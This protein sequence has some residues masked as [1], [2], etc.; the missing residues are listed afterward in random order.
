MKT[1][2]KGQHYVT[3]AYLRKFATG[4]GRRAMLYVYERDRDEPYRQKPERAARVTNYYSIRKEDGSWDD[5]I[6]DLLGQVESTAVP[7]IERLAIAD[8]EPSWNDRINISTFIGFQEFRVPWTRQQMENLYKGL[9]SHMMRFTAAVPG[10]MEADLERM[11]AKGIDVKDVTA[12]QLREMIKGGRYEI[13]VNPAASLMPMLE[14]VP[15]VSQIYAQMMWTV[16]CS[17]E[18]SLFVTSDNPVV[19]FDPTYREGFYGIGIM[20]RYIEI[21]FPLTRTA[22]LVMTHDHERLQDILEL[23]DAGETVKA[24]A[25]RNSLPRTKFVRVGEETAFFIN[26]LTIMHAKTNVYSPTRLDYAPQILKGEPGGIR[27]HVG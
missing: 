27:I 25:V 22:C 4:S 17:R 12:D 11:K 2:P 20:N 5:S 16:L 19:K 23:E 9:I 1:R 14:Q 24:G 6:E 18:G 3:A 21:R 26:S 15:E 7:L 10:Q 8:F 13:E